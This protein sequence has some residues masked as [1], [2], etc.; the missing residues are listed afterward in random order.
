MFLFLFVA[1]TVIFIVKAMLLYLFQYLYFIVHL[2]VHQQNSVNLR[3]RDTDDPTTI[4]LISDT[5][6]NFRVTQELV[7]L[8]VRFLSLMLV[9]WR[10]NEILASVGLAQA[11]P[12]QL[13]VVI[14][15]KIFPIMLALCSMLSVTYYA[16]NHAG[17]IGWSL[18]AD[19]LMAQPTKLQS[20]NKVTQ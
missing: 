12:N 4:W 9:K 6:E 15:S 11:R 8:E 17:I 16:Q 19:D 3:F 20:V 2:I 7:R 1:D 18:H 10:S 13:F 14:F 5:T